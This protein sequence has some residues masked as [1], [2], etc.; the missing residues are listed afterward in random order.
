MADSSRRATFD[1]ER[2]PETDRAFHGE[3]ENTALRRTVGFIS[4]LLVYLFI[5]ILSPHFAVKMVA[6]MPF[7]PLDVSINQYLYHHCGFSRKKKRFL[8][9]S[10]KRILTGN[11]HIIIASA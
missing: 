6:L 9:R 5:F 7:L 11:T 10:V 4:P 8:R 2:K 1:H 3:K